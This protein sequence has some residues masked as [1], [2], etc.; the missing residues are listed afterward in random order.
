MRRPA[1]EPERR[2]R[3]RRRARRA[4]PHARRARAHARELLGRHRQRGD[5]LERR[6]RHERDD[7]EQ[8][9]VEVRAGRDDD[10][11]PQREPGEQRHQPAPE[12]VVRAAAAASRVSSASSC[13]SV[14]RRLGSAPLTSSSGA[15]SRVS[16]VDGAQLGAAA[17]RRLRARRQPRHHGRGEHQRDEHDQP[18][19]RAAATTAARPSRRPR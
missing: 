17:A 7:G 4:P 13:A 5:E 9:G 8:H 2:A 16:T 6:E 3:A 15:P 14:C 10:R 19:R 11:A 12:P 1:A 18:G